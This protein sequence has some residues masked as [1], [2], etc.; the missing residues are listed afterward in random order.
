MSSG[1]PAVFPR[2]RVISDNDYC[3][4][5]DGLVQLAHHLL[6]PSVD[7][8]YVIGSQVPTYDPSWSPT[9]AH[10][11]VAAALEVV[12][13]AGRNDVQ[14]IAGSSDSLT[15]PTQPRSTIAAE[16]IIEEA[17]R[18][19]VE[20]PLVIACGG[21]LTNIASAWLMEP[22][23]ADH[24][25]VVWIGGREYDDQAQPE[26][27]ALNV[28][29]NT[30]I[31]LIA[32][33]VVFNSSNLKLWQVP[34]NVY[35]QVLA[36][37]SELLTH[38]RPQGPLGEHL[39]ASLARAAQ[40]LESFGLATGETY[41]LGDSPLVLLTALLANFDS[42]PASSEWVDRPRSCLLDTGH[43]DGTQTGPSVRIFTRIDARLVLADLFAKLSLHATKAQ[44]H[45]E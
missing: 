17:L 5:P 3:G 43:Y 25:T 34:R 33:Q 13:L 39:F 12:A 11:S 21:S 44:H 35:G 41:I 14:V 28:E 4:D 7:I 36:S 24:L 37:G 38:M 42:T 27:G 10:D 32:A 30:S 29:Y 22:R 16:A 8:R 23:I 40:A 15:S 26:A 1:W 19:D 6:S 2:M 20:T 18:E 9:C 31:D 45:S